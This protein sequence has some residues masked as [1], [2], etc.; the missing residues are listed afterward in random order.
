MLFWDPF[1]VEAYAEGVRRHCDAYLREFGSVQVVAC[2]AREKKG[3]MT[4]LDSVISTYDAWNRR[5]STW[6][7]NSWLKDL[8]ISFPPPRVNGKALKVKFIAQ[9]KTRPPC[10]A[11][12]ANAMSL[13][14][15]Y[16]RFLRS[17]IQE[18]FDLVG[19]PL[20]FLIRKSEGREVKRHLLKQG[21]RSKYRRGQGLSR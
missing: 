7:L 20:R 2:S 3:V 8:L 5:I 9:V 21:A 6:V 1:F 15:F 14:G 11:I 4:L 16:E 12:F 19:V 13:P 18:D 17:R 10:F